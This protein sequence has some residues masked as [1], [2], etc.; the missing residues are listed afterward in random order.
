[1]WTTLLLF[2]L[3]LIVAGR[4]IYVRRSRLDQKHESVVT[5]LYD[6]VKPLR[7]RG[8]RMS[9]AVDLPVPVRRYLS[10]VLRDAQPPVHSARLEQTGTF[11]SGGATSS[12][13][14]FTATQHVTV[15]PPGFVWDATIRMMPGLSVRVLDACVDGQGKLWAWLGGVVPVAD[16][17]PGPALNEGE[18]LRY[19]AEAPLYPTALLPGMGVRWTP[20]SNRSARATLTHRGTTASLVFHVNDRN[21][22]EHVTGKRPFLTDDGTYVDR[23]WKGTW[24]HYQRRDGMLVP[25]DGEVAWTHP[26]DGEVS[27]WRGHMKTIEYRFVD[28]VKGAAAEESPVSPSSSR[29]TTGAPEP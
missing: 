10:H 13:H 7:E 20:I 23:P 28:S 11:R 2:V 1:M 27:Y 29:S 8:V 18:L 9:D 4:T 21:E 25:T 6:A 26:R 14:A 5:D 22:V 19:L 16:P 17:T 3:G 12:W 15:Y 24:G